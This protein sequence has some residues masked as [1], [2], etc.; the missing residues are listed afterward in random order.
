MFTSTNM[1][2]ELGLV[3]W[4]LMGW[5]FVLAEFI[6]AFVLI[7]VMWLIVRLTLPKGLEREAREHP[8]EEEGGHDHGGVEE[9]GTWRGKIRKPESWVGVA[10]SFVM[11]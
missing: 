3:L 7:G 1:V 5:R 4:L 9:G 11:N 10:H 8:E 2:F 6:G